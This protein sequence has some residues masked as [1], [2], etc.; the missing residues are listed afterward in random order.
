MSNT[1]DDGLR[2]HLSALVDGELEPLEAIAVQRHL[3]SN[4]PLASEQRRLEQLKLAVHLAG[5]RDPAPAEVG[6]RLLRAVRAEADAR[7]RRRRRL[8]LAAPLAAAAALLLAA[9]ASP[10]VGGGDGPSPAPPTLAAFDLGETALARLVKV[11]RGQLPRMALADMRGSGVLLAVETMPEGFISA[12]GSRPLLLQ[13]SY[14]DCDEPERGATL[15]VLQAD[16]VALP[17][18]VLAAI[19]G[20]GVHVDLVD[21]VEV[22]LSRRGDKLFVLL[23][24]TPGLSVSPI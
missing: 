12:D 20:R 3:R 24:D 1:P 19:E 14:L 23:S 17:A 2:A 10:L 18:G 15:A 5:T 21:G 4:A 16:R 9:L 13:A 11:H 22:R 6:E 7:R 8:R